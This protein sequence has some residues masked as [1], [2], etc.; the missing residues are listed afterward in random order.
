MNIRRSETVEGYRR[1]QPS[2]IRSHTGKID[3]AL[4]RLTLGDAWVAQLGLSI[5]V[6][7]RS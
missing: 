5:C 3:K 4:K 7:L 1:I 2:T 6:R